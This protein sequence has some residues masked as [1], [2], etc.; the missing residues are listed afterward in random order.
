MTGRKAI[1]AQTQSSTLVTGFF[2]ILKIKYSRRAWLDFATIQRRINEPE[3]RKDFNEFCR[4]MRIKWNS[5]NES[6]QDFSETPAFR[7]KSSWKPTKGHPNL[8]RFLSK[9]EEEL[10]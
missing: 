3:L 9:I 2:L 4:R 1:F 8:E 5:Q 10:F 7:G 6:S